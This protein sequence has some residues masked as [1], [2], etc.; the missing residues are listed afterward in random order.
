VAKRVA[1]A[2]IRKKPSLPPGPLLIQI[3]VSYLRGDFWGAW[4]GGWAFIFPN[5]VIVAAVIALILHSCYRLSKLGMEDKLQ[6]AIAS[7]CLVA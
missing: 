1:A 6:W 3:P 7:A 2:A 5:F 4:I